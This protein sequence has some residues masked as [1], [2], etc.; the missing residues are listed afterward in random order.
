M[1]GTWLEFAELSE[2]KKSFDGCQVEVFD[3]ALSPGQVGTLDALTTEEV[4]AEAQ[5]SGLDGLA[6]RREGKQSELFGRGHWEQRRSGTD[7]PWGPGLRPE[8]RMLEAG[9]VGGERT[10]CEGTSFDGQTRRREKTAC[11]SLRRRQP[12]A[13]SGPIELHG[14]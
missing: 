6:A 11:G 7:A 14:R 5:S 12:E 13:G 4:K 3:F 9:A 8:K 2:P 10:G 1:L